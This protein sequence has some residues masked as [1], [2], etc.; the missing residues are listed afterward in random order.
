MEN[1]ISPS[2][3]LA[4]SGAVLVV[5]GI[6]CVV[7]EAIVKEIIEAKEFEAYGFFRSKRKP[8]FNPKKDT[9]KIPSAEEFYEGIRGV[10]FVTDTLTTKHQDFLP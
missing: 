4:V 1:T 9:P 3:M 10:D 7:T 5:I 8:L 6:V 2:A